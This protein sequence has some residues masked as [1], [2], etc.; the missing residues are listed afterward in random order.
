[1]LI[2]F[3]VRRPTTD[4]HSTA[5]CKRLQELG[6]AFDIAMKD[7]DATPSERLHAATEYFALAHRHN[8]LRDELEIARWKEDEIDRELQRRKQREEAK[9]Q[10][11]EREAAALEARQQAQAVATQQAAVRDA[12][13]GSMNAFQPP[14]AALSFC[15]ITVED[16]TPPL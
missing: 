7:P 3:M 16:G 4:G 10:A 13:Q 15:A 5:D 9:R 11:E 12:E 14:T 2:A 6:D 1:M 8:P